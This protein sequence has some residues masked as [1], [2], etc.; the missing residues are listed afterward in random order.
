M[1]YIIPKIIG[2]V[3][4]LP[5]P[6]A[7]KSGVQFSE[8]LDRA[9][10]DCKSYY[11]NMVNCA[12]IEN[13]GDAPFTGG[14]VPPITISSMTLVACELRR[15]F[16]EMHFGIDVLRNDAEAALSIA[17]AVG[18]EFIRVNV[19]VGAVVA[20]QGIIQGTAYETLRLR[21]NLNSSV[22]IFAD[23]GV[24]H[25]VQLGNYN[26]NLQAADALER[27]LAD[28][29][30]ITGARTGTPIDLRELQTLRKD[31]PEAKII[32]GSGAKVNNLKKLLKY[33]DSIIV[34][35]S[36]KVDGITTNP[37]DGKRV[38]EFVNSALS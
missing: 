1:K 19:H 28:A 22:K 36:I 3:H 17:E 6:G 5:L 13:F 38:R 4:L 15:Q 8:I 24:K 33:A 27:G 26:V 18:A 23:I 20:D 21:K 14:K 10:D 34:G 7:P 30:I 29:I 16:P 9:A 35:T 2:V 12:I 25:S 32:V 11:D 31:F 37:V